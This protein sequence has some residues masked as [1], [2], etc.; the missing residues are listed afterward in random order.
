MV[1]LLHV[2]GPVMAF[3]IISHDKCVDLVADGMAEQGF[4]HRGNLKE[5][6]GMKREG[7]GGE[8]KQGREGK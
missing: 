3:V 1:T 8:G 2:S 6:G 5:E 4:Q 7:G